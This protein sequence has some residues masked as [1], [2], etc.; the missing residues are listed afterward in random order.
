MFGNRV[1]LGCL[2]V[3]AVL[4]AVIEVLFL[5]SYIGPVPFPITAAVAAVTT[6]LL[7]SA[8][9]QLSLRPG[10]AAA[11]LAVWFGTVF[12]FSTLG[13]GG[14]VMLP[15]GDWRTTLFL[16]AGALP[17]A[18]MLGIVGGRNAAARASREPSGEA[19]G[20]SREMGDRP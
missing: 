20:S 9:G 5:P 18:V 3:D 4:L 17:S 12:V 8:A 7:V 10:V 1:L 19:S 6:P 14:D 2:L 13:P 15:G 11:P 16:C